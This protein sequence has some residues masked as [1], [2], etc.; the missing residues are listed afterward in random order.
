MK[1]CICPQCSDS[2]LV[3]CITLQ[4]SL[5]GGR[6]LWLPLAAVAGVVLAMQE[7]LVW[8]LNATPCPLPL[9]QNLK[10]SKVFRGS[11]YFGHFFPYNIEIL[12]VFWKRQL[13]LIHQDYFHYKQTS[14]GRS[15]ACA[16]LCLLALTAIPRVRV[17]V[18]S[19]CQ[20][21]STAAAPLEATQISQISHP[22]P[23]WCQPHQSMS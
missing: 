17:G 3:I 9:C 15:G 23:H 16:A 19:E 11:C 4:N 12:C 7:G 10:S 22:V 2:S 1:T 5:V 21:S 18:E 8:W 20:H 14:H 6:A 13:P